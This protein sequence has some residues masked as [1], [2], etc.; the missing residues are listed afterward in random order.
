MTVDDIAEH[1]RGR[2]HKAHIGE[3]KAKNRSGP[4]GLEVDRGSE[5]EEPNSPKDD[6]NNDEWESKLGLVYPF[7]LSCEE[8]ADPIIQRT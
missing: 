1:T 4:M 7:V 8:D 3:A 2:E 6:C 5:T